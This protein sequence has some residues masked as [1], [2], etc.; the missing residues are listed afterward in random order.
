MGF[1]WLH[2]PLDPAALAV[3][4][5]MCI[6]V[7]LLATSINSLALFLDAKKLMTQGMLLNLDHPVL[8]SQES[9]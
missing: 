9:L 4:Q 5:A 2:L 7:L 1:S 6:G 3:L 8:K